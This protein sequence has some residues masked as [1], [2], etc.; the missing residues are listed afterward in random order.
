M[1]AFQNDKAV[2]ATFLKRVTL[3][4]KADEIIHGKYWEE[5][6]G[7]AVGCTIHSSDHM[8][9][10][11]ELGIPVALARLQDTLFEGMP[12]GHSKTFPRRFLE[13]VK[14]GADL[15]LVQWKFLHW[16]QVENH[17]KAVKEKMPAD[18]ISAIKQCVDVLAPMTK[19]QKVNESAASAAWSAAS[20]A[21]KRMADKLIS[22]LK[23]AQ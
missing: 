7:C 22:L 1:L 6:K 8:A 5:G 14:V 19:G 9:Y 4:E 12:N 13:A 17:K 18:V 21:Y 16:L 2:K 23:S 11:R 20:A 15:S 10:E 3:H